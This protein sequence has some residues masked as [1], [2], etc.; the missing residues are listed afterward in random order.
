MTWSI[1][2]EMHTWVG[3]CADL[4]RCAVSYFKSANLKPSAPDINPVGEAEVYMF[5]KKYREAIF[6]LQHEIQ[7]NPQNI[8]AKITLLRAFAES[9]Q[10]QK[11][12]DLASELSP[13]IR[14]HPIWA[15]IQQV[16]RQLRPNEALFA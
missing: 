16:G 9:G 10:S 5:T 13:E 4:A 12:C 8:E 2:L 6:V 15:K 11:F 14:N 1:R 7:H 3:A